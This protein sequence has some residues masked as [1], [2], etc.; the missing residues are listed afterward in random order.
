MAKVRIEMSDELK[1]I[2]AKKRE[3]ALRR[4]GVISEFEQ[5]FAGLEREQGL[6]KREAVTLYLA[7]RDIKARTLWRWLS[8]YKEQGVMGLVDNRGGASGT[9]ISSDAWELFKSMWLDDRQPSVKLC[10]Q[11]LCYINKSE[12]KGWVIPS[13]AAFY[14]LI[15]K[16][17]PAAVQVLHREG[18]KAYKAKFAPYVQKDPESVK[19]GQAWIGD[20]NQLNCW[21]RHR[22]KWIRPWITAWQDMRSRAIVGFH[23]SSSPNQTTIMLAFKRAVEKHG[24]PE[25]VKI[26]NGRDYDSQVWT[27]TTKAKRKALKAGYIDESLVAG[28]YAMMD[29][30]VSFA[31]PYNPQAKGTLERWF[32]T[33]DCQFTKTVLTYCGKDTQRR[34]EKLKEMLEDREI[35]RTAYGLEEFAAKAGEYIEI[36]NRTAHT[37][38]GMKNMTPEKVL[39]RRKSRR[40]L[41]EGVADLVLRIWSPELKV[42]KNG[43]RFKHIYFGQFNPDLLAV[44]GKKVRAAYDPDDLRQLYVYDANTWRLITI[45]EQ[46]RLIGYGQPVPEDALRFAMKAKTRAARIAREYRD[47]RLAAG[48]DLMDLTMKAMDD[49]A[50]PEKKAEEPKR[51]RP[52]RTPMDT[53]VR[54]HKRREAVKAVKK[55]AGAENIHTVLDIDFS[56]L[57]KN[58]EDVDLGLFDYER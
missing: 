21:V 26:D 15:D 44:Q 56:A 31:I 29:V 9:E 32:D 39:S 48:T 46:N 16:N 19:P 27:G 7:G 30:T 45:A 55:A 3:K 22:N 33:L 35:I 17:I 20:H 1:N 47:T 5:F 13:L 40:V 14:R 6:S 52:V 10:R 54:E 4:L 8:R 18:M 24:P 58:H 42:G 41:A 37:G 49:A 57:N 43:V 36:Y 50:E 28:I 34:P 53:Q 38:K 51:L 11:N 23:V 12:E 25:S 2:P